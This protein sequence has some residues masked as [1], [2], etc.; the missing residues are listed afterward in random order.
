MKRLTLLI[1]T[2]ISFHVFADIENN[3]SFED[4]SNDWNLYGG[5][6][7][8]NNNA[9]TGSWAVRL[10]NNNGAEQTITGLTPNTTYRLTGWGKVN[11]NNPLFIGVKRYGGNEKSVRFTTNQYTKGELEF[12]TGFGK[13]ANRVVIYA[14]KAKGDEAGFA[15]NLSLTLV[16]GSP[17][18]LVW[19]DEFN[20]SGQF[21]D[22]VWGNEEGF[23]RNRELQW[24]QKENAFLEGGNLVIEGRRENRPN[25][26][27][28]PNSDDWK[29]SRQNINYSSASL[30]TRKSASW[31]Y[32][33]IVVRA[34]ITNF[35]GTWPAIWT[36]GTSCEWPSS[37]EVDIMENYGGNL[38][39]N[40][41]WGTDQRW[42]PKWDG[43]RKAVNSFGEGWTN[44]YHIWELDWDENRMTISVDGTFL[45]DVW[46]GNTIN[47]SAK[48]EGQNPF[49]KPQY[50]LLNLALGSNGGS[51]DNLSFPTR[52]LVDYVRVY[53][54]TD[55]LDPTGETVREAES[56]SLNGIA[57]IYTDDAASGGQGVAFLSEL[58]SGMILNNVP[59]A[60]SV[61]VRYAS[62]QSGAISIFVN[63]QNAANLNFDSTGAWVGNYA[64]ASLSINI[65][66]G[67]SFEIRFEN[68]D[69]AMNVDNITFIAGDG[70]TPEPTPI[71]TP[72]RAPTPIPTANP[73]PTIRPTI[74][75]TSV[76]TSTPT[77]AP[78]SIPSPTPRVSPAPTSEWN[79]IVHKPTQA[80]IQSCSGTNGDAI[81]SR[82]NV[83]SGNCVQWK[84]V[85]NGDFFHLQNRTSGKYMKPDTIENGS[86]ISVQ[87]NAWKGNWTQWRYE[88]RG[89]G[90]GHIVNR[91]T[92][93]YIYLSS[94][95][96][97][98]VL[99]QS[100]SWRGDFTRW[101]FEIAQ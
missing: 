75:P 55:D 45:N 31:L 20:G 48:C 71:A 69:S 13:N 64:E 50:L 14:Y 83:N 28:D 65:P 10:G 80:K 15:D 81:V 77:N 76:P 100:S 68:G 26:N 37:G 33:R 17:Y 90:Y 84:R 87:P 3:G 6:S 67:A 93:K 36:L 59:E 79:F 73:T 27:Y 41:A 61:R 95:K 44:D 42:T 85:S 7:R 22:E 24:Y 2:L 94:L 21:N 70:P 19:S 99:Q 88:D 18:R 96:N 39:A 40:Y 60:N 30:T 62:E 23:V 8:V 11:G 53:Q 47:G 74:V 34:K 91:A 57:E 86:Q 16:G 101:K 38:L 29:K 43:S 82:P 98:N 12:T 4:G 72:T 58:G 32:G 1:T 9:Q 92:G 66:T 78:T 35:V 63:G 52:Y 25:P 54:I 46:L 5:A 49:K 89:D 51:V 56:A 97:A